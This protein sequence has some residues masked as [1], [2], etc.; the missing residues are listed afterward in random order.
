MMKKIFTLLIVL[1]FSGNCILFNTLGLNPGHVKGS[2]AK[3][4]IQDRVMVHVLLDLFYASIIP[5]FGLRIAL[6][7]MTAEFTI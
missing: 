4:I 1:F 3:N 2:E 5:G 6:D 7:S